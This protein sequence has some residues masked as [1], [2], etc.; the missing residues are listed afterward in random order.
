MLDGE[1]SSPSA[2]STWSPGRR[3][4]QRAGQ[5]PARL[6]QRVRPARAAAVPV[7]AVRAGAFFLEVGQPV[8]TRTEPPP[9]LDQAAQAAFVAKSQA[10]APHY[11]TELLGP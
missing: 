5:R 6:H 9:E 2:A 11:R 4:R 7:L 1:S 8:A 10:L 3:D